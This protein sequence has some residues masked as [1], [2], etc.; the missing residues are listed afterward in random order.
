[1]RLFASHGFDKNCL[2]P[3]GQSHLGLLQ[4]GKTEIGGLIG[5]A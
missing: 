3:D 1:M 2:T 5:V 4:L